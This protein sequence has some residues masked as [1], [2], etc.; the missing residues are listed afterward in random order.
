[1]EECIRAIDIGGNGFRR[2]DVYGVKA[3][4]IEVMPIEEIDI[5]NRDEACRQLA[6]FAW[7]DSSEVKAIVYSVAGVIEEN[8][9]MVKSPNAHFLEG[10]PLATVTKEKTK[11]ESA[12]FNDMESAI[13]GMA[14]LLPGE[15]YFLGITV[16]S[17]IGLRIWK[18]GKILSVAEGGHMKIDFS[19]SAPLCGCGK[20]GCAEAIISGDAI[21]RRVIAETQVLGIEL[22]DFKEKHPCQFLDEDYVKKEA[23]ANDIYQMFAKGM[24]IFL[25]NIQTLLYLPLIVW[26]GRF[27]EKA[28][29]KVTPLIRQTMMDNLI[30]PSWAQEDK[31]RFLPTLGPDDKDGL[32]GAAQIFESLKK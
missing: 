28:F 1:M 5:S 21:K 3:R 14:F 19:L 16:S 30:E 18:D 32:I 27:A 13:T 17:G 4:N 7:A 22:S 20:R 9:L 23:W 2:G 6:D 10:L 25:A 12:V 11:K 8:D 15:N 24:G 26:K 31:L 29:W